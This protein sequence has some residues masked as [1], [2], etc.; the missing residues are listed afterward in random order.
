[1]SFKEHKDLVIAIDDGI[2]VIVIYIPFHKSMFGSRAVFAKLTV[3]M[4]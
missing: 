3:Y 1:M 4:S 2:Q